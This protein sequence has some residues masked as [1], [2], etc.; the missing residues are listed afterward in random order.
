MTDDNVCVDDGLF[1]YD[2]NHLTILRVAEAEYWRGE[3]QGAG[4]TEEH[5]ER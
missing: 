5:L 4:A 2:L 3:Q 1:S